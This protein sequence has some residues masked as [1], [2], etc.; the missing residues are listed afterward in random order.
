MHNISSAILHFLLLSVGALM[1]DIILSIASSSPLFSWLKGDRPELIEAR[2]KIV[3]VLVHS[4]LNRQLR[5][6]S[7]WL[8][9]QKRFENAERRLCFQNWLGCFLAWSKSSASFG[10]SFWPEKYDLEGFQTLPPPSL[11]IWE[12]AVENF[13]LAF[14][15]SLPWSP[16]SLPLSLSYQWTEGWL[17]KKKRMEADTRPEKIQILE[18][19]FCNDGFTIYSISLQR[20]FG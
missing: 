11:R 3:F 1:Y 20:M 5:N 12:E 19:L 7:V 4:P 14:P 8:V 6:L 9:S 2:K 15:L 10:A 17:L 18:F 13:A 16:W